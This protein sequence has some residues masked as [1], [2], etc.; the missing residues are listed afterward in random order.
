M[1][2]IDLVTPA[3]AVR[4]ED[5]I[6]HV[7]RVFLSKKTNRVIVFDKKPVGIITE[8]DLARALEKFKKPIDELR[9][10]KVM[11]K[12]LITAAPGEDITRLCQIMVKKNI[13]SIPIEMNGRMLGM[14]TK[15]DIVRVFA[16]NMKGVA[17]VKELMT[18]KV[19]T[20]TE[21]H[22]LLHAERIMGENNISRLVVL[23]DG[24]IGGIITKRD[25][26]FATIQPRK[27]KF[28]ILARQKELHKHLKILPLIVADA[29]RTNIKTIKENNDAAKAAEIMLKS[30]IGSLVVEKEGKPVGIITK[31]DFIKFL[32]EKR[33]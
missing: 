25:I 14:V 10:D 4:P 16:K 12:N 18:K 6:A 30:R 15:D 8:K 31:T 17:K 24:K 26:T 20:I 21:F 32:T 2:A 33:F 28:K 19:K 27:S 23:R 5:S 3:Y 29:M 9:A 13:S 7:R 22:S 11:K 1:K